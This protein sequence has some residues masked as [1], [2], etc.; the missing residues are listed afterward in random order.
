MS[1][2]TLLLP[3][4]WVLNGLLAL[5]WLAVDNLALVLLIPALA[6][7]YLLLGQ[8]L[9]EAQ[10]RR[11]R[12]VLL[13]AAGLALAAVLFAPSPAPYL[14]AGLAGV[15]GF[16]VK[17]D[18]YR[19]DESAWESVQNLILY[20]LVGLGA[21]VLFWVMDAQPADNLI[22]GVN[23]LGVLASFAL[24]GMPVAQAGLLIKNLLA[25]APTGADPRTVIE[26][27]RERR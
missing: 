14:L 15:S 9:Q 10:A 23:Y 26:R 5:V 6:W 19:P 13:P 7:L 12:Q 24:W 17:V 22:A 27:A 25:H 2:D 8:R 11:M 4:V 1:L 20:A 16:V 21:R 3:F 18:N